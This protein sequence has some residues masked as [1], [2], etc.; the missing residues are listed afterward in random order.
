MIIMIP[1]I[2]FKQLLWIS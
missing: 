1:Y 2:N